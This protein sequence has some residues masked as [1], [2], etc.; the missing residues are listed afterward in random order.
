MLRELGFLSCPTL[1]TEG[2]HCSLELFDHYRIFSRAP[3]FDV[4]RPVFLDKC[5]LSPVILV[6][7]LLE[8]PFPTAG[9]LLTDSS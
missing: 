7:A 9:G 4:S 8:R 2:W 5:V 6:P 3:A 1:S